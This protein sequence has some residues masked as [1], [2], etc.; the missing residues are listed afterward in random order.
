MLELNPSQVEA[1][2]H[3]DGPL[4][5]VAGPG[6]GKTRVLTHRM[7]YLVAC[8][9]PPPTILAI[10][11]T[12][13]AAGE[14]L[15]RTLR[16]LGDDF[17]DREPPAISTFHAYC[18][19][20]LRRHMHRL[21]PFGPDFT[22]YDGTDQLALVEEVTDALDLERSS[23]P[24]AATLA[25]ISRSK[26]AMRS[27]EEALSD[28]HTHR[29]RELARVF[30]GYQKRLEERNAVDFD[31]LL[32]L[33]LR[34]LTNTPDV[35]GRERELRRY[36]LVDEFQ[37]TN[38]PQYLLARILAEE[39][40]NLCIT[41][42]PDQ[43]IYSW[44]GATPENFQSFAE[45]FPE[46]R[47][48]SLDENYRSTPQIIQVASRLTGSMVGHRD[49]FTQNAAGPPVE[50]VT[51]LDERTEAAHVVA[52]IQHWLGQGVPLGE[53][54]ILYR[55]NAQ[56]RVL[57]EALVRAEIP[58]AVVG[59]I[60]F[61]ERK[62]IKDILAYLRA[63][64]Q[65]R[66]ELAL[67]RILNVPARGIG[68]A[69][70]ERLEECAARHR[71]SLGEAIVRTELWE[72]IPARAASALRGFAQTLERLRGARRLPL[73]QQVLAA[74]RESG[75]E[76]HLEKSEP[77][78]WRDRADNQNELANAAAEHED[79]VRRSRRPGTEPVDA[80]ALFLERVSLVSDI[81]AWEGRSDRISLMTLHSAKGL[82]FDCVFIGGLEAGLLPHTRSE[83]DG[84]QDEER[85]LLYVGITR[86]RR[87]VRLH[88]CRWRRRF[89]DLEP[90]LESPFLRELA[91]EGVECVDLERQAIEGQRRW[92]RAASGDWDR[93]WEGEGAGESGGDDG[94]VPGVVLDHDTYGRGTVTRASGRGPGKRVTVRFEQNGE[95]QFVVAFAP[96]RVVSRPDE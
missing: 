20:L 32:L 73:H 51:V 3:R 37:D 83:E 27:A 65:P 7:A 33:A 66:D 90:R 43:A 1:V 6:S 87:A 13:K 5:V 50:V 75:Y 11:F 36:I 69:T 92:A 57:E 52:G 48:V 63:A 74:V 34:L 58:Y 71:V 60:S 35:L 54:A 39:H 19:R 55:I 64:A 76:A 88:H 8:S 29:A 4:M 96:F 10:T 85:R 79:L 62:E 21:P 94:L 16:L 72:R 28:A 15:R 25:G 77:E 84:S 26:N 47:M 93:D 49:F 89:R 14:M 45:D 68:A 70:L 23:F 56:S 61:Y 30:A 9:V 22:I 78:S 44:R 18:A 17:A 53:M 12:N 82:E 41:G 40:R 95:R 81:D 86:A 42:D 67:R 38:R 80:L 91:G 46:Y 59:G 31:D 24:P 2:Q